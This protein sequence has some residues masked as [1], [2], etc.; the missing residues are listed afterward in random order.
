MDPVHLAI[1]EALGRAG[2]PSGEPFE[3]R[4]AGT[5]EERTAGSLEY[6]EVASAWARPRHRARRALDALYRGRLSWWVRILSWLLLAVPAW[7]IH[8]WLVV[9]A[10]LVAE[11]AWIAALQWSWRRTRGLRAG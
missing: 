8:P 1:R 3:I 9:P 7:F 4:P 6:L 11:L 10:V 2:V 5:R